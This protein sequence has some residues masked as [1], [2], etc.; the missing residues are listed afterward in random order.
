MPPAVPTGAVSLLV[1]NRDT[2]TN[3]NSEIVVN[4]F[5]PDPTATLRSYGIPQDEAART[6]ATP[7]AQ[8]IA[9]NTS[10]A[11][12]ARFRIIFRHSR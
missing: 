10:S 12:V 9:T 4:G 2:Q 7:A 6:N 1:I 5:T 11:P 8:D 3:F